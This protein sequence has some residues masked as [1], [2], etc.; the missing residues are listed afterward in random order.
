MCLYI[1]IELTERNIKK[2][3]PFIITTKRI[4]S[5][6]I[7]ITKE[8]K[9]LFTENCKT[10]LKKTADTSKWKAI[11]CSQ[12]GRITYTVKMSTQP[13]EIHRFNVI[14]IKIPMAFLQKEF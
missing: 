1:N 5:L 2:T 4:K 3:I 12:I 13:K 7:N 9:D 11:P 6:R 8:V 10:L 14:P